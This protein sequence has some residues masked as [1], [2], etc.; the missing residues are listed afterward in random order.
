MSITLSRRFQ[1]GRAFLLLAALAAVGAA[2]EEA[3]PVKK[4]VRRGIPAVWVMEP[5]GSNPRPV[6]KMRGVRWHGSATWSHDG[7]WI[8]F[9]ATTEG[10]SRADV[11][12]YA[13]DGPQKGT[14]KNLGPGNCPV[15]SPDGKT[16][17]FH[18]APQNAAA[19]ETGVWLMKP[20]GSDRRRL[21][22]G[23]HPKWSPDG[24]KLLVMHEQVTPA[25]IDEVTVETGEARRVLDS[26]YAKIPGAAYSPDGRKMAFIGYDDPQLSNAELVVMDIPPAGREAAVAAAGAP[27]EG[28]AEGAAGDGKAPPGAKVLQ[29]GRM[30]WVPSWS[31]DGRQI[32]FF[33]WEKQD[34]VDHDFVHMID[35]DGKSPPVKLKNQGN[36]GT[37]TAEAEFTA[38]GKL[39]VCSSDREFPA[40]L[41][42]EKPE[43]PASG[44]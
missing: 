19:G 16:I 36:N 30:G 40:D 15:F 20:D 35:V 9:D 39:L 23:D 17:A 32:A 42:A 11:C 44:L 34:G 18:L 33:T 2:P 3:Q 4:V 31:P 21:C 28:G 26:Q 12:V 41:L 6:V 8:A 1:L 38:D 25:R 7:K 10:F 22:D 37:R 5:D 27:E 29:R 14:L 13:Y 24:K 43:P